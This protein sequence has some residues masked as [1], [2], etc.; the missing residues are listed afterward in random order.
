MMK[1]NAI[2]NGVIR[3]ISL[4][5]LLILLSGALL[6]H[7]SIP[8]SAAE[9]SNAS[10]SGEFYIGIEGVLHDPTRVDTD[11]GYYFAPNSYIYF[12]SVYNSE[13]GEYDPVLCRVL[14]AN[15]DNNGNSGAIFLLTEDAVYLNQ[16]FSYNVHNSEVLDTENIYTESYMHV[17]GSNEWMMSDEELAFIRPI[18]KTDVAAEMEGM[19]GFGTGYSY[20][21]ESDSVEGFSA[22]KSNSAVLLDAS[23]VFP[24]SVKELYDYV[25]SYNGAPG[26]A[27]DY[28]STKTSVIW[29]LRTGLNDEYGNLVGAVN[30]DGRVITRSA[31]DENTA[32]RYAFNLES[33]DIS[34]AQSVGDNVYRIAFRSDNASDFSASIADVKDGV[35]EISY[36]G[37]PTESSVYDGRTNSISVIIKNAEGNVKHY[38]TLGRVGYLRSGTVR[39]TLPSSYSDGDV[40]SVFWEEKADNSKSVSYT[41]EM[42]EL[43]CVHTPSRKADCQ[44]TAICSKCGEQYGGNDNSVHINLSEELAFDAAEDVHWNTCVDCGAKVNVTECNLGTGCTAKCVCGNAEVFRGEHN[45]DDNGICIYD[46]HHYEPPVRLGKGA[47]SDFEIHNEGQFLFLAEYIN[48]YNQGNGSNLYGEFWGGVSIITLMADLD[49]TGID[50]IAMGTEENPFDALSFDGN[51]HTIKGIAYSTD[52]SYAGIFGVAVD[53]EIQDITIENCSLTGALGAGVLVGKAEGVTLKNVTVLSSTV[54]TTAEDG[55]EG[56]VIGVADTDTTVLGG[57][58]SYGVRNTSGENLVFSGNGVATVENSF[59]LADEYNPDKGEMTLSRF[60]SGEVGYAYASFWNLTGTKAGQTLGEDPYPYIGGAEIFMATTCDGETVYF[61]DESERTEIEAHSFTAFA[62]DPVEFIWQP[63]YGYMYSCHVYAICGNCGEE[64]LAEATVTDDVYSSSSTHTV[65]R[66]DFHAEITLGDVTVTDTMVIISNNIQEFIGFTNVTFSFDGSYVYPDDLLENTRLSPDE[67]TAFFVNPETGEKY[68]D[69]ARDYYEGT[70]EYPISVC[71]AGTYDLLVIGEGAFVGQEY[72]YEGALT[73]TPVTVTVTPSDVYRYYDGS[74]AFESEFTTDAGEVLDDF[75]ILVKYSNSQK[76][77]AG[78]Y[79]L[80]VS[81]EIDRETYD[82][83]CYRDSVKLV[84]SRDTVSA[85]ILPA[86]KV[87]I[88]NKNYPTSFTYGDE[89]PVPSAEHFNININVPLFFEWYSAEYDYYEETAVNL[90]K[91]EGQPKNAGI[92]VL[93]VNALPTETTLSATFDLVVEITRKQLELSLTVPEGTPTKE[94]SENITYYFVDSIEDIKYVISGFVGSD[95]A[96]N[97]NVTVDY[98]LDERDAFDE[99]PDRMNYYVSYDIYLNG[100]FNEPQ[101]Y[102]SA[103]C[104]IYVSLAPINIPIPQPENY[105]FDGTNKKIGVLISWEAPGVADEYGEYYEYTVRVTHENGQTVQ[106]TIGRHDWCEYNT[107]IA[108]LTERGEY[109][110]VITYRLKNYFNATSS[111]EYVLK[112][113]NFTV[114][115]SDGY[116][117]TF[118]S[119]KDMGKYSVSVTCNGTV[120]EAE[121]LVQRRIT[122]LVKDCSID[123]NNPSV[124]FNKENIVMVA[125]EVLMLGHTL[126]DVEF[127]I[128]VGNGEIKVSKITVLDQSGKD[129]SYLYSLYNVDPSHTYNRLHVYD[130]S[131]DSECNVDRCGKTKSAS[132]SGGKATCTEL[133]TCAVCGMLYGELDADIHTSQFTTIVVNPE[134]HMTHLELA[135]CCGGVIR[136]AEHTPKT[137][138]T[139]TELAVCIH[140]DWSYGELDPTNHSSDEIKYSHI[141]N[142][143]DEHLTTHLCCGG[144]ENQ[145]HT[146]GVATCATL[147]K[148]EKCQA[149]YGELDGDNHEGTSVCLPSE[150]STEEHGISYS[151]CN[152]SWTENHSGGKATCVELAVCKL[153]GSSYGEIDAQNHANDRYTYLVREDN[154]SMH[155]MFHSCCNLYIGKTYHSGGMATCLSPACCIHCGTS[156]GNTDYS[157]HESDQFVY[158]A[159]GASHIKAYSCCSEEITAEEHSTTAATCM[160][161]TLCELCGYEQGEKTDHVYDNDCDYICNVCEAVTRAASFHSDKSND[162]A[163]DVCG[164]EVARKKLSGGAVSAIVVGSVTVAGVGGFSLFWFVIKKKSWAELLKLLFG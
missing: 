33:A 69:E 118:A 88:D 57:S 6:F 21:W 61:N 25:A 8:S 97:V 15:A 103:Y 98:S 140:C 95:T 26:L 151:C 125:G 34:Y 129:V 119:I 1:N 42:L 3:S 75:W 160:H 126:S 22:V 53:T 134:D 111:D 133:A 79:T 105:I 81:V 99:C 58:I 161:G 29:W 66:I 20:A 86:N 71:A 124:T 13:T 101:N 72:Y 144:T 115:I 117:S 64:G 142:D 106:K 131:C 113:Y 157:I 116:G 153:C 135:N 138:A 147:A 51:G 7:I 65:P 108:E 16:R 37:A 112:N 92:Y 89:I 137:V 123:L 102:D 62:K 83:A 2:K 73:I 163:C 38:E 85:F 127:S 76:A 43:G 141:E 31:D 132:H 12:G 45:F 93:R 120:K 146:G 164:A 159:N 56:S 54:K 14:D 155:D 18:T 32:V 148:C 55:C 11:Q 149:S 74:V 150:D 91:I 121:I 10:A 17:W 156:Y 47:I 68:S 114:D 23:K 139:C 49:F 78:V 4:T 154:P 109:S 35:V 136:V 80:N 90:R 143:A 145:A 36:D 87:L 122:M 104:G 40:I 130:S 94:Y 77:D 84:L 41:G 96:D 30:E 152:E 63:S 59:C 158:F 52:A 44:N 162:G 39:F 70:Y 82:Y 5:L 60:E 19:F 128:S 46:K 110:V 24:L 100:E 107:Y 28:H 50:Y 9:N 48:S 67:Y 27:V